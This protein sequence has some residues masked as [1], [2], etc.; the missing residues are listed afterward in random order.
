MNPDYGLLLDQTNGIWGVATSGKVLA[1]RYFQEYNIENK[2]VCKS[3]GP[4]FTCFGLMLLLCFIVFQAQV[5]ARKP[6]PKSLGT[7]RVRLLILW[8]SLIGYLFLWFMVIYPR[9]A[10]KLGGLL[11]ALIW[12]LGGGLI[13]NGIVAY[14][15]KHPPGNGRC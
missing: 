9:L 1:A 2:R 8:G 13:G 11:A 12:V 14:F 15:K 5:L 7:M 3:F 6:L 10:P 4:I